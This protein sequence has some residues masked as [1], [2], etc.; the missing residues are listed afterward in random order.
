MKVHKL[1]SEIDQG[2]VEHLKNTGYDLSTEEGHAKAMQNWTKA[3]FDRTQEDPHNYFGY[4]MNLN[5]A[6]AKQLCYYLQHADKSFGMV[7]FI[8]SEKMMMAQAAGE[9]RSARNAFNKMVGKPLVS[10]YDVFNSLEEKIAHR[11][12][13]GP[14]A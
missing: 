11:L 10:K 3:Y 13:W 6:A 1:L 9:L 5:R 12:N 4:L 7:M 14:K 8:R 2:M